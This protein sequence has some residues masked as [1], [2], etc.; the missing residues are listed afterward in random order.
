MANNL[1]NINIARDNVRQKLATT[2]PHV[3]T[4]GHFVS[5]DDLL[6]HTLQTN[7]AT[8]QSELLCR[9]NTHA[10]HLPNQ[11]HYVYGYLVNLPFLNGKSIQSWLADAE[12]D[13]RHICNTCQSPLIRKTKLINSLPLITFA[14][15]GQHS[16]IIN[17]TISIP[18]LNGQLVQYSLKGIIYYNNSHFT[19][20]IISDNGLSWYHDG[21]AT[22]PNMTCEGIVDSLPNLLLCKNKHATAGIYALQ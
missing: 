15:A 17:P 22:G 20:R 6:R 14:F 9:H 4:W 19:S 11:T 8:M 10:N 13:V 21:M 16:Y 12:R 1:I 18:L 7:I 2:F 5:L 3:F